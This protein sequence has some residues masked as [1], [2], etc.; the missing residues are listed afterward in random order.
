MSD[1]SSETRDGAWAAPIYDE[2]RSLAAALM[3]GER[4]GHTLAPTAL[5]HETW[6]RLRA[7]RNAGTLAHGEFLGLASQA[8]RRILTEHARRRSAARRGGAAGRTSL[9]DAPEP[10]D[11][12]ADPDA[13]AGA[14]VVALDG[15]LAALERMDPELARLVELRFFAGCSADETAT[16]LGLSASTAKRR[17]RFAKAWLQARIERTPAPRDEDPT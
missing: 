15:A 13:E 3:N 9:D 8:M 16:A 1:G 7:S 11:P 2:L 4:A 12:G 6:L 17:W 10:A 5:V 14:T